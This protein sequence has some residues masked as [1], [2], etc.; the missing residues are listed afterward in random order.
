[1]TTPV[2]ASGTFPGL[3]CGEDEVE[4]RVTSLSGNIVS[5][6]G[7]RSWSLAQ[8]TDAV[9]G[10]L[11]LST[12]SFNLLLGA[13]VLNDYCSSPLA[14]TDERIITLSVIRCGPTEIVPGQLPVQ[15]NFRK[16][17]WTPADGYGDSHMMKGAFGGAL[18]GNEVGKPFGYAVGAVAGALAAP[19]TGKDWRETASSSGQITGGVVAAVGGLTGGLVGGVAQ[20]VVT[21]GKTAANEVEVTAHLGRVHD[22]ERESY[23]F[24]D[25][26]SG[27][28]AKGRLSRGGDTEGYR[29][30]DFTRGL[31]TAS[32]SQ[33][34]RDGLQ[35]EQT[36]RAANQVTPDGNG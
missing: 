29:F 15:P 24:G 36:S 20:G 30:G 34:V 3:A 5:V 21:G 13:G 16:D 31:F 10:A 9:A 2:D 12:G 26:T 19:V 18:I 8:L 11:G 6:P 25:L 33:A 23:R 35:A 4:L 27:V 32:N 14:S 1:M 17:Y 22:P 7:S 28:L